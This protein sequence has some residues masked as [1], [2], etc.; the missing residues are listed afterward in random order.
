MCPKKVVFLQTFKAEAYLNNISKF[1]TY[2]KK[3]RLHC[4]DQL[5]NTV[6]GKLAV[7]QRTIG[8]KYTLSAKCS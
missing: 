6:L 8:N 3:S 1:S 2:L 5:V 4:E 7:R